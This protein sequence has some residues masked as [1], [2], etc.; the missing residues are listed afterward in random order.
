MDSSKRLGDVDPFAWIRDTRED[1]LVERALKATSSRI[2]TD[3]RMAVTDV[4]FVQTQTEKPV[5]ITISIKHVQDER[6]ITVEI[7]EE[8]NPPAKINL[9]A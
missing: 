1:V 9:K 7:S 6:I 5:E 8:G 3:S 2:G 4:P